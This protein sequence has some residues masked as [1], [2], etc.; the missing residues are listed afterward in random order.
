MIA[1]RKRVFLFQNFPP[2][3]YFNGFICKSNFYIRGKL[4]LELETIKKMILL[5]D[6]ALF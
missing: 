3:V 5:L 1:F 2:S 4:K 6:L